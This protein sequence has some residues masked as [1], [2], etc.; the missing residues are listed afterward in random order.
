MTHVA[1]V[2]VSLRQV[3]SSGISS[4]R[5]EVTQLLDQGRTEVTSMN[6]T[7]NRAVATQRLMENSLSGFKS[8][9]DVELQSIK[10]VTQAVQHETVS[11]DQRGGIPL[12]I[13]TISSKFKISCES[14]SPFISWRLISM[15]LKQTF[16]NLPSG[17]QP[18]PSAY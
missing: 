6:H 12:C 14:V 18:W 11:F 3:I 16:F 4:F 1:N 15:Q 5:Q 8:I 13:A 10:D 7:L 17:S 2:T 9:K